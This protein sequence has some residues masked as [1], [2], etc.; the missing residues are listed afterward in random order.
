MKNLTTLF[1]IILICLCSCSRHNIYGIYEWKSNFKMSE[2][3]V[4]LKK[5]NRAIYKIG[6][7]EPI[8]AFWK[9]SGD[10][11]IVTSDNFIIDMEFVELFP[12]TYY[13]MEST[14]TPSETNGK[15]IPPYSS[16]HENYIIR[17]RGN[18][19][20]GIY[21]NKEY[22][23]LIKTN[24]EEYIFWDFKGNFFN[25]PIDRYNKK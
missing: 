22:G 15:L 11:L 16:S 9:I 24:F 4:L 17:D 21:D 23:R 3:L 8:I 14:L 18:V 6:D 10:T 20:I 1:G 5:D 2:A 19:L 25:L 7:K 13:Y 12:D